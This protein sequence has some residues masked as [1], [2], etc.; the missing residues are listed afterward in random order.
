MRDKFPFF[1]L[2]KQ[3]QL[4]GYINIVHKKKKGQY[5]NDMKLCIYMYMY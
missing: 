2:E 5:R 4:N 3:R 1:I